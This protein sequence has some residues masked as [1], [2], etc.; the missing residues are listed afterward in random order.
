MQQLCYERHILFTAIVFYYPP[1]VHA[2]MIELNFEQINFLKSRNENLEIIKFLICIFNFFP[3][4][5]FLSAFAILKRREFLV[6][7]LN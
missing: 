7:Q 6:G 2:S 5:L 4:I 1:M 3:P